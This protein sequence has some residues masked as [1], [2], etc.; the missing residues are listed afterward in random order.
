MV[1]TDKYGNL[2]PK[3]GNG[4]RDENVVSVRSTV[5]C[6]PTIGS[7][8]LIAV[9]F[10]FAICPLA[11]LADEDGIHGT[12]LQPDGKSATD[13]SIAMTTH[14]MGRSLIENGHLKQGNPP[15]TVRTDGAGRFKFASIDF[16]EESKNRRFN[17]SYPRVDYVLMFLHDTG[18]KRLTQQD[19][20]SLDEK[21]T[22][23]LEPWA[24]IEGT[25]KVGTQPGKNL[26][27]WCLVFFGE[28]RFSVNNEPD[29]GP[30]MYETT[31]DESGKF[32]I[33]RLPASFVTIGRKI[34]WGRGTSSNSHAV[35]RLELKSGETVTVV[36]GGAGRPITGKLTAAKEF[37]TPPNWIFTTITCTPKFEEPDFS[38]FTE[39]RDKM[40]PKEVLDATDQAKQAERYKA[41]LETE[42]GKKYKIAADEF[43]KPLLEAQ[44]RKFAKQALRRRCAVASDGTFRFDDIF[45]GDWTLKVELE[46]QQLPGELRHERIGSVE[47][48]FSVAAVPGGVSDEPQDIGTLEVKKLVKQNPFP[49][50]GAT[51]P[52]FVELVKIEPIA[53]DGKFE[54]KGEKLRLSDYKGKYVILDFWATWCGPCL[55]KLPE[56]KTLYE[57]IKDDERFVMIGISLD[58]AGSEEMLGKFI[59]R[60]EMPWLHGLSGDWQSDT[61][62]TYGIQA[63]PALLLLDSDGKVLL[64][65]PSV[66]ELAKKVEGL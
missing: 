4:T 65:N 43:L 14:G 17:P 50:V 60:R 34:S 22:I 10:L 1:L 61:V 7:L 42:A 56:L 24:R 36:I 25:V 9:L 38:G 8:S 29:R 12:V 30:M 63:I 37:E 66:D 55:A 53:V 62:R 48:R 40:L 13:V 64:S 27:I 54:D 33:D 44:E 57:K 6:R 51:A 20:E 41:W 35:D 23:T 52:E 49:Q 28:E 47:H 46:A 45:E 5:V 19:W 58:N 26:P 3:S 11:V 59:V 39:F 2:Q 32:S 18:F 31:A 15:Y 21:K 16:D